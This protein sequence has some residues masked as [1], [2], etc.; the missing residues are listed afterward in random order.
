MQDAL[1]I[2]RYVREKSQAAFAEIVQRYRRLVYF[3][4][5]RESGDAQFAEDATQAVFLILARK[6][7]A[8]SGRA[9][10]A[11]WLFQTARL[12]AQDALKRERRRQRREQ[13]AALT[14]DEEARMPQEKTLHGE[15]LNDALAALKASE[16]EA[17]LLRFFEELNFREIGSVLDVSEDTAQKRVSRALD[18]MRT[19]FARR[20]L[21]L[22]VT[23]LAGL[24]EAEGSRT[25][26]VPPPG[27][28]P[29][30][31]SAGGMTANTLPQQIA[32]G[33]LQAMWITKA[34][35]TA[36]VLCLGLAAVGA[37]VAALETSAAPSA[38]AGSASTGAERSV[39]AAEMAGPLTI[40]QIRIT[41]NHQVSTADILSHVR[42]KP[43]DVLN[44]QQ[45]QDGTINPIFN[46]GWFDLVGPPISFP[47]LET[48]KSLLLF[49]SRKS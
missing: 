18:K 20:D 27:S 3:T 46:M 42:V 30:S 49:L 11:G 31:S 19:Q 16:R 43:G 29:P 38:G 36:G 21:T 12:T 6:A 24:L 41:G 34:G 13:E 37:G 25:E 9:S 32:Q 39:T 15:M 1:L 14:A 45:I 23:A 48:A 35:L 47:R 22:T 40:Q 28:G 5:L 7:S 33:V 26:P 8:L 44:A 10:L 2:R 17:V 4:C